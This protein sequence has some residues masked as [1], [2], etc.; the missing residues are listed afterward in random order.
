M[1][2]AE[3]M[4]RA[5]VAIALV[6]TGV[7]VEAGRPAQG[8]FRHVIIDRFLAPDDQPL[9]SYK[10]LRRLTAE[11]RGGRMMAT[12]EAWTTLDPVKGFSYEITKEDGSAVIRRRVLQAA[13]DAE[14]K[15][16][17]SA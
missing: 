8:P 2:N 5:W 16:V 13:L 6:A 17:G 7:A 10:A 11:T 4:R 12:L 14:Q 9:V 3:I 15:A 1:V